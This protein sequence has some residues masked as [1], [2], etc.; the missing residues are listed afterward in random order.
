MILRTLFWQ[1]A[2]RAAADPRV[3]AKAGEALAAA[4]PVVARAAREIA[5]AAR[6]H[7]PL[8]DPK[9]FASR[10]AERLAAVAERGRRRKDDGTP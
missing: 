5:E 1:L 2:R 3:R 7:Q 4:R 10:A 6:E 8:A 9:A